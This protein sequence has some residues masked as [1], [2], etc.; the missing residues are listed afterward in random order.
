[1]LALERS[2]K[3]IL[4]GNELPE[5]EVYESKYLMIER[6]QSNPQELTGVRG[7]GQRR[8]TLAK[9]LREQSLRAV[10]DV[11]SARQPILATL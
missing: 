11:G 9:A 2:A 5:I 4:H 10:K 1:M 6:R 8:R 3:E 7:R